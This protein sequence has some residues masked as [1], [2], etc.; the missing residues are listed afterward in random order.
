MRGEQICHLHPGVVMCTLIKRHLCKAA[1]KGIANLIA[2]VDDAT[3]AKK[4]DLLA[5]A[6]I[7]SPSHRAFIH[8]GMG[9]CLLNDP[10]VGGP[11]HSGTGSGKPRWFSAWD[12]HH[13]NGIVHGVR[14]EHMVPY[15]STHEK[16]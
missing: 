6:T 10:T 11:S 3:E 16:V 2:A 9:G 1:W 4:K 12:A 15:V 8:R 14:N 7:R 5:F 13:G